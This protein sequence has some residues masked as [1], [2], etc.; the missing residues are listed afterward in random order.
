MRVEGGRGDIDVAEQDLDDPRIDAALEKPRG[1]AMPERMRRDPSR[2]ARRTSGGA[3][4]AAQHLLVDRLGAEM[5][6]KEPTGVAVCPPKAAQVVK[7]RLRQRHPPFLVAFTDDTQD[8]VGTVDRPDL[9]GRGFA[10]AQAA[11]IQD[12]EAEFVDRVLYA[13]QESADLSVRQDIGQASLLR[14]TNLF[15]QNSGQSRSSVRRYR[16]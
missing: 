5:I 7:N 3:E 10:D 15:F 8:Q 14:R 6:G 1:I 4:G 11:S 9:Q 12:G 13:A 2:D 16:N